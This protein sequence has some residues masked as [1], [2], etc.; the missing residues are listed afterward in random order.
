MNSIQDIWDGIMTILSRN[1]TETSM[2]TWFA[3]CQLL[4]IEGGAITICTD[5]QI[6]KH[7]LQEN[8]DAA[9]KEAL[10]ELFSR[11][12]DVR[13]LDAE[14]LNEDEKNKQPPVSVDAGFIGNEDYTFANFVVGRSNEFAYAA[15]QYAL[16]S[17]GSRSVNPLFLYGNSGLGKTHLLFALGTAYRAGRP[18]D[19]IVLIKAEEF[20][21][22]MIRSIKEGR[23]Q[24]FRDRFRTVDLLLVDDIQFI[25]GKEATQGEFFCTFDTVYEA[26]HQ[27][28]IASDRPPIDMPLLNEQ[29]RTRFEGGVMA[30]ML[31]PDLDT[32][33][34]LIR[35]KA[36]RHG[37]VLS[38]EVVSLVAQKV[39]SNVRQIEGVVNNLAA[40]RELTG[41]E[42]TPEMA[43]R[44]VGIIVRDSVFMPSMEDIANEVSRYFQTTVADVKGPGRQKNITM[45][46]Q[47]TI[48]MGRSLTN[49]PETE[50]GRFVNRDHS[51]VH[52]SIRKIAGQIGCDQTLA[53]AIKDITGNLNDRRDHA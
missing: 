7:V 29:L 2:K 27:I 8:F 46:R 43:D 50:I 49:L 4:G 6:K 19:R 40:M 23:T 44:A 21:N 32:R 12:Y 53:N 1:L 10:R 45:A 3:D 17:P 26:G 24:E 47:I 42:I 51:T 13:Y 38:D 18:K 37:I 14:E 36:G 30:E 34:A 39:T 28:V 41:A 48:Y 5:H 9:I 22:Q 25:A 11:D 15:A 33:T 20:T 16:K 52:A 35:N 31:A